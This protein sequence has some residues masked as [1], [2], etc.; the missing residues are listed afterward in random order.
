ME[1]DMPLFILVLFTLS[2]DSWMTLSKFMG[3]FFRM[4]QSLLFFIFYFATENIFSMGLKSG[5][6][7]GLKMHLIDSSFK[8]SW[9]S[10]LECI[11]RL[12][13][14]MHR[15]S[16]KYLRRSSSMKILNFCLL[17]DFLKF[18]T[19]SSPDSADIAAMVAMVLSENYL[20]SISTE[21][22]FKLYSCVGI[23]D[24]VVI[25]SST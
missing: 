20:Q 3:S 22:F 17:I 11:L 23:V 15:S 24:R 9:T 16:Q 21:E 14:Y 18:M 4:A 7:T 25:I 8:R 13:K 19:K 2:N 1:F 5:L 6:Y 12:S 10:V